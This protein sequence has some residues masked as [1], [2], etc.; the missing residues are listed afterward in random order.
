MALDQGG[1]GDLYA[2]SLDVLFR[3]LSWR[4]GEASRVPPVVFLRRAAGQT[5]PRTAAGVV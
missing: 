1:V 5:R 2:V 3:R 4:G